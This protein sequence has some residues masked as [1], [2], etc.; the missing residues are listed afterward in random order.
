MT[1]GPVKVG[2]LA[3]L[4]RDTYPGLGECFVQLRIGPN[5]DEVLARVYGNSAEQ[6]YERAR[7]LAYVLS[8]SVD[9][10]VEAL[11]WYSEQVF[12]CRKITSEGDWSRAALDRDGG[13]RARAALAAYRKGEES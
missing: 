7:L 13:D 10:L 6:A 1:L 5:N 11:E 8:P 2:N 9:E 12:G 3:T 4:N